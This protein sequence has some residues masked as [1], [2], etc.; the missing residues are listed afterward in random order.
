MGGFPT[1]ERDEGRNRQAGGADMADASLG[2]RRG[3]T[4]R[5]PRLM[6]NLMRISDTVRGFK[7]SHSGKPKRYAPLRHESC[8]IWVEFRF[9]KHHKSMV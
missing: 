4:E 8:V 6:E 9:L 3:V 1:F 5:T 2:P 7:L